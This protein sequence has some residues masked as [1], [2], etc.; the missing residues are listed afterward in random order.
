[1]I[2][3]RSQEFIPISNIRD[4]VVILNNG[5]YRVVLLT[6]SQNL[7]LKSDDE[8]M[9]IVTQFQNYLNSLDFPT[10]IQVQSRRLDIKNY[11]TSL[12]EA[13]KGAEND[14][15]KIQITEYIDFIKKFTSEQNIMT[16]RFFV[17]IPYTPALIGKSLLNF[18]QK[19]DDEFPMHREQIMERAQVVIQG[20]SR[21]GI[22][23]AVLENEDLTE[24]YYKIFNPS[25]GDK[26]VI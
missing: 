21:F 12:E 10:E 1:M 11:V 25:G 5:E 23:S 17:I 2:G 14:L 6:S 15:L 3:A 19:S 13:Y 22:R 4:G 26:P 24:L 7:A 18:T 8:Q 20:L 16:K 9:A